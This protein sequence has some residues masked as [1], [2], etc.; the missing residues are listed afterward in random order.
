MRINKAYVTASEIGGQNFSRTPPKPEEGGEKRREVP[1]KAGGDRINISAEAR[2]LLDRGEQNISYGGH[3]DA[4]YDQ[5]GHVTR[6]LDNVRDDLRRVASEL[7]AYPQGAALQGRL[8]AIRS[9][10][11]GLSATV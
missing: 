10:L 4:T 2:E 6:Q 7:G 3:V 5:F 11:A 9:Q 8:G 1:V